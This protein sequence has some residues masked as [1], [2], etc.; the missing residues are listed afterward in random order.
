[1]QTAAM[2]DFNQAEL[3]SIAGLD[4][5][6]LEEIA[7][8]R[9]Q[10]AGTPR[11]LTRRGPMLVHRCRKALGF[12]SPCHYLPT[13]GWARIHRLTIVY[14]AMSTTMGTW[15]ASAAFGLGNRRSAVACAR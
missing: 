12:P 3:L 6:A 11:K 8:Y 9:P 10:F 2:R 14:P 5:G 4:E 13:I 7:H 1:M 15:L